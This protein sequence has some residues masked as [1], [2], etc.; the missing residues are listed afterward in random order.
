MPRPVP[1]PLRQ[2]V[3]RRCQDGQ[4][5]P[6][7]ATALGLAPRTVRRLL[8]RFRSGAQDA[9]SPSYGRC[10]QATPKPAGSL[11]HAA[12]DLRRAHPTWGAGLI[13]VMLRR[14]LPG[15][16]LP[17]VRTLQR[18]LLRAGLSPAP[19]GRRPAG[20]P[21]RAT[22]PHEVWQV[23]AAELV[24]L[25]RGPRVCW[26]RVVDEC[27]GAVLRTEVFPPGALEPGPAGGDAGRTPP[28]L[29]AVGPARAA[30]GG[31]RRALG[32]AR[33]PADGPGPV[34][35]RAGGGCGLQPARQPPGQRGG[36]AVAGDGPAVGRAAGVRQPGAAAAAAGGDGRDPA[37]GVPQRRGP[38]PFRGVPGPGPLRPR[39]H[40]GVGARALEPGG[41]GGPPGRVRGAAGGGRQRGGV[42][43]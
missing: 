34:A 30:P 20:D 14:Q 38:E 16:P 24:R 29:R 28:G 27:S 2:A 10:G 21:R 19:A 6:A 17:A 18:W 33:R 1:L 43:V 13:R 31:Q 26:L 15:A 40:P 3:W 35:D 9:L 22:R 25:R 5:G 37:P 32:V 41:G 23:G 39:V 7:I 36:G 4:D 42:G 12:L 8:R 11:V